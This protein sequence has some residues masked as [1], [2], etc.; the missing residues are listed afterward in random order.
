[1][2]HSFIESLATVKLCLQPSPFPKESVVKSL[3]PLITFLIILVTSSHPETT[4][5]LSMSHLIAVSQSN[6]SRSGDT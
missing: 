3:S 1:M 2:R 6:S 5:G 4:N